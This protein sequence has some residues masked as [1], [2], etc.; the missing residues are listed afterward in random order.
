MDSAKNFFISYNKADRQMAEWVAWQ[1]E[2]AG[3]TTV[4]QA[5]DFRPGGNFVAD[6]HRAAQHAQRTVAVLSP[7]YLDS[8]YTQPEWHAAFA[9]DPTGARGSLLPVRVRECRLDGLLLQVVYIDLVGKDEAQARAAL[10]DGL[11]R[12]RLKPAV[13]PGFVPAGARSVIEKPRYPGS[14]PPVWNV[15]HHRNPNF[16]GREDLLAQLRTALTSGTPAALT[17]AIH[18]LGGV[19]KTQLA[20]EYA[21]RHAT[22][23]ELVWWVRSEE[24]ATLAAEYARLASA[25]GLPEKDAKEQEAA[26]QAVRR[27]LEQNAGWLLVFDNAVEDKMLRPYLPRGNTGHVLITS[28]NQAWR[29]LAQPL[30]VKVLPPDDAVAFLLKRTG[31]EEREAAAALARELGSLPLALEQAGAYIEETATPL[32]GYLRLFRE[33]RNEL[34]GEEQPP[35]EYADTVAATWSLAMDRVRAES[36][37]AADLLNLCAFLAPDDIPLALITAG[38]EHLPGSLKGKLGDSLAMNRATT[39]LRRYSLVE[40]G[41]ETWSVHRLVQAVVI[42]RLKE[43]DRK[44]WAEAAVRLVN[45]AFPFKLNDVTTWPE[46]SRLLPHVRAAAGHAESLQVAPETTGRILNETGLYLE[47]RAEFVEAKRELERALAIDE[48]AF[49]PDHPTV[50]I[51][52]NNLGNV[53]RD[54]GDLAGA[55]ARFERALAIDERAFGPDHPDV[56]IDVNNLGSVLRDLGDLAGARARFERA[57]AIDERAFGPDHSAVARDVN[58]LGNVLQDLGD[59]AGARARYERALA[60]GERAFGPDH[61]QVATFANNLGGVLRDLGDLAGARARFE[62]ALAIGERAFGPDHPDV[63][64]DVS[65]LGLVLQDL[66]DLAGARAR[67]ERA[68]RIFQKFLGEDHPNTKLVRDNLQ[69]LPP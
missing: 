37:L 33:R 20:V 31:Q 47:G 23:Y 21:Y 24:S 14:L 67:F 60:I 53:L 26:V 62:R 32:A 64:I 9:Q 50:A 18:G 1:L 56:A 8:L 54:L 10:L 65:N 35:P 49:G 69:S 42:D 40:V 12:E 7:D 11:K 5:W 55:R 22:D 68:L 44:T 61:P 3:F 41:G 46:C 30:S 13:A 52:V 25:L 57:L 15:P 45:A 16:T 28:R 66:G 48:R 38:G 63:A 39:A 17:Q 34:W 36:S 58:N 29:G 19:G 4:I 59:L 43:E 27:W 51:R 2:E 6:M